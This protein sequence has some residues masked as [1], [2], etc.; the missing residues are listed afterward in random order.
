MA[1]DLFTWREEAE[2][3]AEV[4]KAEEARALA[5]RKLHCAPHGAVEARRRRL[6]AATMEALAA[7]VRLQRIRREARS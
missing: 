7:E 1:R 5:E 2:A 6:Q 3:A 4:A